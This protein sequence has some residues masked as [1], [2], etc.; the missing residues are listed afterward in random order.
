MYRAKKIIL[1]VF[2]TI[3]LLI[4]GVSLYYVYFNQWQEQAIG[5]SSD[6]VGTVKKDEEETDKTKDLQTIIH[7]AEKH[8]VQIET[9]GPYG[10]N[11]GSGFVYND[12]GDV[13]T[14]AHVVQN[15]SEVYVKT[16]DAQNYVGAIIGIGERDDIA[17]I[18]VPQLANNGGLEIDVRLTPNTGDDIIAIGSPHGFQ[19]TVTIGTISGKNRSFTVDGSD[20]EYNNLYQITA[21]IST[22]NS[23][24]PL[25]HRKTGTVIAVNSAATSEGD[26]GFSIPI[27][28]VYDR[29]LMWSDTASNEELNYDGDPNGFM[30]VTDDQLLNDVQYLIDYFY[31]TLNLRDYFTAYSLLGSEEQVEYSYPEFRELYVVSGDIK[32]SDVEIEINKD[33]SA[34]VTVLSDH[35]I[36]QKEEVQETH[37]YRTNFVIGY[38]N[39][40]LKILDLKR[41][42]LSKTEHSEEDENA[43]DEKS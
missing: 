23:G 21:D 41:E 9:T 24:G 31:E 26:M 19:N 22:G 37:H 1:P 10:K 13:V 39:D 34:S 11:I 38:E 15:A 43:S 42:L 12:K 5:V 20:Y 35:Q 16:S 30:N 36:L 6:L 3:L 27:T 40:Q 17:L 32:R 29:L 7:D 18:R 33:K 2:M 28:Q 25:I 4:T 14:N 8:V